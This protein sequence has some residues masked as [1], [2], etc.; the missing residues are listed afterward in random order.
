MPLLSTLGCHSL[1]S[2]GLRRTISVPSSNIVCNVK[3]GTGRPWQRPKPPRRSEMKAMRPLGSQQGSRSFTIPSV[4]C[5]SPE[6]SALHRKMWKVVCSFQTR[7]CGS[8]S[9]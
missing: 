7:I 5:T 9:V 4:S 2:C 3:L 8:P 1:V 6:P